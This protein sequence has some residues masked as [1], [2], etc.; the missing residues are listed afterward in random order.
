MKPPALKP[1]ALTSILRL[2]IVI[3]LVLTMVPAS[4]AAAGTTY[5]AYWHLNGNP[6]D[7]VGS[8][9][10]IMVNGS[11]WDNSD[12]APVSGNSGSLN[13]NGWGNGGLSAPVVTNA[14]DNIRMSAWFKWNGDA[15]EPDEAIIYNGDSGPNGYGIFFETTPQRLM[16]LCGG[17]SGLTVGN[18]INPNQWM[19]ATLTRYNGQMY[20][21]LD[22][23][24][25]YSG[26]GCT[27][28]TPNGWTSVGY[29]LSEVV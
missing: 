6:S 26:P 28:N 27:P 3:L 5:L 21:T 23:Q 13:V 29:S 9:N 14:V 10:G 15:S 12:Y 18:P 16:I 4:Q 17:V 22:D 7:S 24:L 20:L 19:H 25:I 2:G 1:T 8:Y 11:I